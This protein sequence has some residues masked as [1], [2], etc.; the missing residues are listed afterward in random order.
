[1]KNLIEHLGTEQNRGKLK[2]KTKYLLKG[3]IEKRFQKLMSKQ[4]QIIEKMLSSYRF[5]FANEDELQSAV[6]EILKENSVDFIREFQLSDKDRI[7]FLIGTIGLEIKVG[8]SYSDVI[9]QLHRYAQSEQIEALILLTS[10][11]SHTMPKE[12]NGKTLCTI[13]ISLTSSL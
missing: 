6:E 9:R 13:N 5:N 8:F 10:R 7:D 12:I 1:M 2:L 4:N 3:R 11:L